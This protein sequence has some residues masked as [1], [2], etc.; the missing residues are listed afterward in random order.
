MLP[1]LAARTNGG[2][3]IPRKT[4]L[5]LRKLYF[6]GTAGVLPIVRKSDRAMVALKKNLRSG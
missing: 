2:H 5:I 1:I 6:V 3:A 4:V